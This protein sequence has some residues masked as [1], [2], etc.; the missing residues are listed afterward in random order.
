VISIEPIVQGFH[1]PP[2]KRKK[3][4]PFVL[5]LYIAFWLAMLSM[6]AALTIYQMGVYNELTEQLLR[7]Q[8]ELERER[9]I[10]S[11]MYLQQ[12]LFDSDAHIEQLARERLGLVRP[13]EVVFRNIAD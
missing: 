6:F 3:S 8:A 2:P 5:F 1:R 11:E 12:L 13:N 10:A 4:R 9:T 7:V